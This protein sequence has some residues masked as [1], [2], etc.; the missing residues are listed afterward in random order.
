[1]KNFDNFSLEQFEVSDAKMLSTFSRG[2]KISSFPKPD[3][4]TFPISRK[5]SHSDSLSG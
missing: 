1:M 3:I 4:L 2:L 5:F